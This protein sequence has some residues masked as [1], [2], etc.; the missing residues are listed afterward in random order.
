MFCK[1]RESS[2]VRASIKID[3]IGSLSDLIHA[4]SCRL[5]Y[6]IRKA[7]DTIVKCG[8]V[9]LETLPTETETA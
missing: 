9:K 5:N 3:D 4:L 2:Y 6:M 7:N 8:L 1:E